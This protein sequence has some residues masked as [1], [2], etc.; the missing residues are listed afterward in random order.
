[1]KRPP[2]H[3][4]LLRDRLAAE[5]G[6]RYWRSLE[7]LAGDPAVVEMLQ[8]EFP[9]QAGEWTDP[10]S[11]RRFLALMG[12]S[13]TLAG[14]AGCTRPPTGTIMPYVRQPENIVLGK[15][16]YYATSMPLAGFATG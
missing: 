1:M 4:D 13:L 15:P 14:M 9:D 5:Q 16:L 6:K 8:R 7:E 3:P 2:P 10:I 12:A 11:R